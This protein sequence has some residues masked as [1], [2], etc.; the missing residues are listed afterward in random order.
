MIAGF[1]L[2]GI[3]GLAGLGGFITFLVKF[4]M[5]YTVE[6]GEWGTEVSSNQDFMVLALLFFMLICTGAYLIY[7]TVKGRESLHIWS[8]EIAIA[9][10]ISFIYALARLIRSYQKNNPVTDYWIWLGVSLAL[11][12]LFLTYYFIRRKTAK[13]LAQERI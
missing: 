5:S 6:S 12:A 3:T 13:R 7:C 9:S 10:L 1:I 11:F 8:L 4:I 2:G